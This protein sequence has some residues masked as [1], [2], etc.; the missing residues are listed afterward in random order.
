MK[1][2]SEQ[3][4]A[5]PWM[6]E[7]NQARKDEAESSS[8]AR[9]IEVP[10]W[11]EEL[12]RDLRVVVISI[13]MNSAGREIFTEHRA[14]AVNNKTKK[15]GPRLNGDEH[16]EVTATHHFRTYTDICIGGSNEQSLDLPEVAATTQRVVPS[17]HQN[18][19][20]N[21]D[22]GETKKDSVRANTPDCGSLEAGVETS[23]ARNQTH[24]RNRMSYIG[25]RSADDCCY[26]GSASVNNDTDQWTSIKKTRI[27]R[28]GSRL[29]VARSNACNRSAGLVLASCGKNALWPALPESYEQG[30]KSRIMPVSSCLG[31]LVLANEGGLKSLLFD[32]GSRGAELV[33]P[34]RKAPGIE[35]STRA[36]GCGV[37]SEVEGKDKEKKRAD[38]CGAVRCQSSVMIWFSPEAVIADWL[39]VAYR[40][41]ANPVELCSSGSIMVR[42]ED[43]CLPTI[44]RDDNAE[45]CAIKLGR[46]GCTSAFLKQVKVY[47]ARHSIIT[48]HIERGGSC[49]MPGRQKYESF[50]NQVWDA[51]GI[52]L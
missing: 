29:G 41:P 6:N 50:G 39:A 3:V 8:N 12:Q 23:G 4:G 31:I 38:R 9:W 18:K 51:N 32:S 46:A 33:I 25:G 24:R 19:H 10:G 36:F 21:G 47:A 42:I 16:R 7:L 5:F 52:R 45:P 34:D 48:F 14:R 13:W 26:V 27:R 1:T 28:S 2:P 20:S 15:R 17:A 35:A 44:C 49:T 43:E 37:S 30:T 11:D 22:A 40:R